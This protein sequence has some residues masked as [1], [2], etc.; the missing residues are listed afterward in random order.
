MRGAIQPYRDVTEF[1][2][3]LEVAA[4]AAPKIQYRI[5][6]LTLDVL[7]Q[8][9][10]VLVDVV[11]ARAFPEIF[12]VLGIV[13][14]RE[15]SDLCQVFRIQFHVRSGSHTH[16]ACI[17]IRSPQRGRDIIAGQMRLVEAPRNVRFGSKAGIEEGATDVRFTP[18]KRTLIAGV[19]MSALCQKQTLSSGRDPDAA[20][21]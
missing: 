11:I 20:T 19:G 15:I 4:G 13:S 6:R 5:R 21:R 12:G 1:G 8:R 9:S 10:N 16:S 7:Q 2:K 14:Q 18:K 3:H 17:R